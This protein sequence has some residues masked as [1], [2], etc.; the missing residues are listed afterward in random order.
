MSNSSLKR[1]N[2]RKSKSKK[3]L[4]S[5]KSS[6]SAHISNVEQNGLV[7]EENLMTKAKRAE[8]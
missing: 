7:L 8:K 2:S 4:K 3:F 1:S 5:N 6:D